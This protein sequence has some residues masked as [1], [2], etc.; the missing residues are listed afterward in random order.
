MRSTDAALENEAAHVIG[1]GLDPPPHVVMVYVDEK[2]AIRTWAWLDSVLPS[3]PDRAE[4]HGF[5]Y[6]CMQGSRSTPR[7][8][9]G[10]VR[11]SAAPSPSSS[12][13]RFTFLASRRALSPVRFCTSIA[14]HGLRAASVQR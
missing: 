5:E 1:L 11:S 4:H 7:S 8:T 13:S 10:P 2:T 12:L 6:C 9:R 3:A 14:S